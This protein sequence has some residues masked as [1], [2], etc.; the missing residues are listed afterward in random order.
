MPQM[1]INF[2]KLV[3]E[4]QSDQL[5]VRTGFQFG[6]FIRNNNPIYLQ[7][8]IFYSRQ[9]NQIFGISELSSE[10]VRDNVDYNMLRIPVLLG[11]KL[12]NIRAYTGPSLSFLTAIQDNTFGFNKDDFRTAIW[13]LNMGIGV[14]IWIITFDFNY[15]L[16]LSRLTHQLNSKAN[17]FSFNM[18]MHLK[19]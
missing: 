5:K 9:G 6:F 16:G 1:G 17:V 14:N 10:N 3:D 4:P 7:P 13:G 8:G 12:L 19:F 18:G 11:V 15:E 2:S